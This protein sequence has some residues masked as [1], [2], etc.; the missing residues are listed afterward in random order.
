VTP[1]DALMI[2]R[3][4]AD[5]AD[6]SGRAHALMRAAGALGAEELHTRDGRTGASAADGWTAVP[7]WA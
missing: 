2:A 7:D 4:R 1:D 5:V 3:R 6:L